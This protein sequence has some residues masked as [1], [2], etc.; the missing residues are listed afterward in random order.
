MPVINIIKFL[1][2]QNKKN[3]LFAKTISKL[4]Q[5]FNHLEIMK[6]LCQYRSNLND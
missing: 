5:Y 2:K 6:I 4:V 3:V 1:D